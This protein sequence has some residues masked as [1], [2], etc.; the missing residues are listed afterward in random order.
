[1]FGHLGQRILQAREHRRLVAPGDG[2]GVLRRHVAADAGGQLLCERGVVDHHRAFGV[3]A[4]AA[5]VEVVGPDHADPLVDHHRFRMQPHAHPG[6]LERHPIVDVVAGKAQR[7]IL[8]RER[9]RRAVG[10]AI[11]PMARFAFQ[12]R[13]AVDDR[14]AVVPPADVHR[15]G[16]VDVDRRVFGEGLELVDV[17]AEIA[18]VAAF[19]LVRERVGDERVRRRQAV[20]RHRHLRPVGA[21]VQFA[22]HL[23]RR[24]RQ[25]QVRR[26]QQHLVLRGFDQLAQATGGRRERVPFV[27]AMLFRQVAEELDVAD[28]QCR[29]GQALGDQHRVVGFA[30]DRRHARGA[31]VL[32]RAP[33]AHAVA[34]QERADIGQLLDR[35]AAPAVPERLEIGLHGRDFGTG[36]QQVAVAEVVLVAPV[37]VIVLVVAPAG[38]RDLAV[39]RQQLAVH[40]LVEAAPA[41]GRS[42]QVL[43]IVDACA[44]QH[45]V[46]DPHFEI[47]VHA[48]QGGKRVDLLQCRQL[49]DQ[50]PHLY[51]TACGCEQLLQRQPACVVLVEDVG[52][53]V[54]P[55][56]GRAQQID[57]RNQRVLPVVQDQGV[58]TGRLRSALAQRARA[59]LAQRG[60]LGAGV[61]LGAAEFA[62]ARGVC[63]FRRAHPFGGRER[64]AGTGRGRQQQHRRAQPARHCPWPGHGRASG[65]SLSRN[66]K[67]TRERTATFQS[68][69]P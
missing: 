29:A 5:R 6:A 41:A 23:L 24:F 4:V 37:V 50:H 15:A 62:R 44:P 61:G 48:G 9:A 33:R 7:R 28:R 55:G 26:L 49:V 20:G 39:D 18:Q 30:R 57:P 52:L 2:P 38:D 14:G 36:Q 25:H 46:V 56:L 67:L 35:H 16:G 54:D 59:Q 47:A 45:R 21:I 69:M 63:H 17:E 8:A 51:A 65:R 1:M 12:H 68:S 60:G 10:I 58:M 66:S 32:R 11:G 64:G 19:V 34:Q 31:L 22:E 42:Q 53:Q 13:C 27:A 43:R 40:A 3:V